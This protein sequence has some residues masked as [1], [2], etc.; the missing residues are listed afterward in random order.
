VSGNVDPASSTA[1]LFA[2]I[3]VERL[4]LRGFRGISECEIEL[5]PDLTVLAGHNNAGK[6]RILSALHLA[7]GGRAADVDDFTVGTNVDPEIDVVLAPKWS[8][9]RYEVDS[10][11]GAR[12][13]VSIERVWT[14]VETS[15]PR[16]RTVLL[17]G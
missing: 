8:L 4:S 10:I 15:T 11:V 1:I 14:R 2:P 6:S 9:S 17:I 12:M 13:R 16:T 7:V 5:E 3:Y